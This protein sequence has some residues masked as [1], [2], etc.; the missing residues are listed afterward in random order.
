MQTRYSSGDLLQ[1]CDDEP[2]H[3][4]GSIQP[5]GC[6]LAFRL[7]DRTLCSWSA[8]AA[9]WISVEVASG[10]PLDHCVPGLPPAFIEE[11]AHGPNGV[12]KPL[13][14]PPSDDARATHA[15]VHRIDGVLVV[16]LEDTPHSSGELL[17][18][19]PLLLNQANQRLQTTPT[20]DG[21]FDAIADQVR[22]ISGYDRVMVY[23]FLTGG[24]GSVVGESVAEGFG[25][26]RG[27]HYP[28]TDIPKQARRLYK[29]NT[30]RSIADIEATP[31]PLTPELNPVTQRPI[32]LSFSHFRAVSPVHVEYLHNM[33]VRASMS[34]SILLDGELWGLVAC[35]HYEPRY[36][37]FEQRAACEVLGV[38]AGAYLTT[39]MQSERNRE[40][41]RRRKAFMQSMRRMAAGESFVGA[42]L[43]E[44]PAMIAALA[45]DG[46]AVLLRGGVK[47]FGEAPEENAISQLRDDF[48]PNTPDVSAVE[49]II[50]AHSPSLAEACRPS[51]GYLWLPIGAQEI[52]GI[53]FFRS[54]YAEQVLWAGDPST[55]KREVA[56]QTR[57]S[58]RLS[59]ESWKETVRDRCREWSPIDL[60]MAEEVRLG[61]VEL[62]GRRA[63]ELTR[64]NEE[65]AKLNADLD[66]FAY[67]A[68]H[69][70]REP[71]RG[72]G[73]NIY[74]MKEHLG[75]SID[76]QVKRRCD[77]IDR[78]LARM[79][80]LIGGILRLSRAGRGDLEFETFSL[81]TVVREAITMIPGA[82][83]DGV[84][85][86]VTDATLYADYLCVRE[87]LSNLISNALKYNDKEQTVITIGAAAPDQVPAGATLAGQ[88]YYVSDNG[89]GIPNDQTSAVFEIFRRL[90]AKEAFGG[91][92]GAG[93]AIV[94]K[95]AQR[96]G[97]DAWLTSAEGEGA[98]VWFNLGESQHGRP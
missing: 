88:S 65:L 40:A 25:S 84:S 8:N 82:S 44:A 4:P 28:A 62:L 51:C 67:A 53:G 37:T 29:L 52:D 71:L 64:V 91:G 26:F 60:E 23:R 47:L 57:L 2:I 9:D 46:A 3:I 55:A 97:G 58:P 12:V 36:L 80:E 76:P 27:L 73:Q 20:Y 33:G 50:D 77:A 30:V 75:D 6:L 72:L 16:E 43:D 59:F 69:D 15:A 96:H 1:N 32:D 54:E 11:I 38:M 24:H 22:T 92:S 17:G 39:G 66:S 49:S 81:E 14:L 98:T 21:L 86:A 95:I 56:G 48:G 34:I 7:S 90:H 79:D 41:A 93:L 70:L 74:L 35:H 87:L 83:A 68:S 94:R 78:L 13:R 45:A 31:S 89:I 63:A 10:V 42:I 85:I 19:L 18:S 5:H 61:L